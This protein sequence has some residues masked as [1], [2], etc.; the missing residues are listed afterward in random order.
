MENNKGPS[1]DPCGTPDLTIRGID[2]V[3]SYTKV[4]S[5]TVAVSSAFYLDSSV[6]HNV[7]CTGSAQFDNDTIS[8]ILLILFLRHY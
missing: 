8:I 6:L 2:R 4:F 1:M 7:F 3:F 5:L